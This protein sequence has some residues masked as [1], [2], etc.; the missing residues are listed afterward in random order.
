MRDTVPRAEYVSRGGAQQGAGRAP[1]ANLCN[2]PSSSHSP[3]PFPAT[4]RCPLYL[5]P[6]RNC[7]Q[8]PDPSPLRAFDMDNRTYGLIYLVLQLNSVNC[9][10]HEISTTI[11]ALQ[12]FFFAF[13]E[14]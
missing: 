8:K 14:G 5:W 6:V 9:Y 10:L 11:H 3:R 1:S 13:I 4:F 2:A 12:Y 7:A